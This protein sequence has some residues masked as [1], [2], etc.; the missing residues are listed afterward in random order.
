MTFE[1]KAAPK[2][3]ILH[4]NNHLI[5]CIWYSCSAA[6]AAAAVAVAV[7]VAVVLAA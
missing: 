3:R 6:A 5:I 1:K 7:A 4:N 2:N